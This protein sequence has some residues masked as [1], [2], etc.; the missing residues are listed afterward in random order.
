MDRGKP[1]G[2]FVFEERGYQKRQG[3]VLFWQF[4]HF[5]TKLEKERAAPKGATHKDSPKHDTTQRGGIM[6]ENTVTPQTETNQEDSHEIEIAWADP[7]LEKAY[8]EAEAAL[9]ARM[10]KMSKMKFSD[11]RKE[12]AE[13]MKDLN[14]SISDVYGMVTNIV[15]RLKEDREGFFDLLIERYKEIDEAFGIMAGRTETLEA[16]VFGA[17]TLIKRLKGVSYTIE[18]QKEL[19]S[20]LNID[21]EALLSTVQKEATGGEV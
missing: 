8:K 10:D 3:F 19:A 5:R 16:Y 14:D 21:F 4:C 1:S 11:F 18:D 2:A 6:A 13:I 15:A 12:A 17:L 7:E 20:D 9:Y